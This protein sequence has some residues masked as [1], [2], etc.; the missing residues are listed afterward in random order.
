M[1]WEAF[2]EDK[3]SGDSRVNLTGKP[4]NYFLKTHNCQDLRTFQEERTP[5]KLSEELGLSET[6][7]REAIGKVYKQLAPLLEEGGIFL[8][9]S[10]GRTTRE[11][12]NPCKVHTWL[13][14]QYQKVCKREV[15]SQAAEQL[16]RLE[17]KLHTQ[18]KTLNYFIEE[19]E[20]RAAI[21]R[22]GACSAF[23]VRVDGDDAQAWLVQRL[24]EKIRNFEISDR[25]VINLK[26]QFLSA[27]LNELW[28]KLSK[29]SDAVQVSESDRSRILA[30]VAARCRTKNVIIA[31]Y[32]VRRM[33]KEGWIHL[34][35]K[36]WRPLIKQLQDQENRGKCILL[37]T[38][39]AGF[40]GN[41]LLQDLHELAAWKTLTRED[42]EDWSEDDAVQ[43]LWESGRVKACPHSDKVQE[44][45]ENICRT[46]RIQHQEYKGIEVMRRKIWDLEKA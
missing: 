41:S 21:N 11:N 39:Q 2:L 5:Q 25:F 26:N 19:G 8:T 14:E 36:F 13:L 30:D 22:R 33:E 28:L 17:H 6:S 4:K 29:Q 35:E 1:D 16:E 18:L 10:P 43:E 38:E 34:Q 24:A 37:L 27:D 9:S 44:A 12:S 7:Y 46:L 40:L 42:W 31:L 20:F 45:L 23:L 32:G 15:E 3:V